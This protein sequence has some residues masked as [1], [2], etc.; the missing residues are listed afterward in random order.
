MLELELKTLLLTSMQRALLGN[1]IPSIRA[2]TIGFKGQEELT[3]IFYFDRIPTQEDKEI[4]SD[5][6]GE[7][8]GD[9][10]FS[11]VNEL[12]QYSKE[13]LSNLSNL[14]AWVYLRNETVNQ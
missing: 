14:D 6:V 11:K 10:E 8:L 3:V 13:P 2:V 4:V 12:C 1:I 7:V 5:T 9:I